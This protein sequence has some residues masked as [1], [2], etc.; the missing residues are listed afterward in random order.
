MESIEI[1]HLFDLSLCSIAELFAPYLYPW[2]V[3]TGIDAYLSDQKLGQICVDI[4]SGATL[5]HPELISIGEG[6]V[7]EPGAFIRG[8]CIIGKGCSIR[9][10]AYIRGRVVVGDHCVVGHA[11]EAKNTVFIDRAQAGH[12][13]YLGDTILGHRCNVGAGTKCANLKLDG[14]EVSV[15]YESETFATHLRKFGA[16][17]GDDVQIGCN[18]VSN[19]GTV[20]GPRTKCYPCVNFGGVIPADS[21]IKPENKPKVVSLNEKRSKTP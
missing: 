13:A 19:P 5:D 11:T 1:R 3:L 6:T 15:R 8:P 4:P 17:F 12:F 14:D 2:Q 20:V 7:V 10:G 18:A 16:I 9:H 21:V